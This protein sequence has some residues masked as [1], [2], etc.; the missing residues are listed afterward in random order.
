MGLSTLYRRAWLVTV[1]KVPQKAK[2]ENFE[3]SLFASKTNPSLHIKSFQRRR[4]VSRGYLPIGNAEEGFSC[5]VESPMVPKWENPYSSQPV[6]SPVNYIENNP[7]RSKR[8]HKLPFTCSVVR[9]TKRR[10]CQS[11]V[12]AVFQHCTTIQC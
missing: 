7:E 8:L 9:N 6:M 5:C 10:K 1:L 3:C 12:L 2:C 11:W 4:F